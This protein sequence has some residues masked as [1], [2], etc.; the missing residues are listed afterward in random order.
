VLQ[1]LKHVKS[2]KYL[3]PGALLLA[4]GVFFGK[5]QCDGP[6]RFL[7][8]QDP[9]TATD[10]AMVFGGDPNF[11]RTRHASRLFHEGLARRLIFCGGEPGPGDHAF[12]LMQV[13]K[14]SGVPV[15][16]MIPEAQSRST[17]ESIEFV[18]P[19]LEKH[20]IRS[21]TLVTSPYHQR[22]VFLS[23]QRTLSDTVQLINSPAE[24]SFWSP[25]GWWQSG[26]SIRIVFKEYG[27]LGYYYLRGWI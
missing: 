18:K 6:A 23:A 22:R 16:K 4:S 21:L 12:G 9:P 26:K 1:N 10:A 11:E 25:R 2:P 20:G 19:I 5:R 3:L 7:V 24:P 8:L 13:A 17:R 15:E 27:K 14:K